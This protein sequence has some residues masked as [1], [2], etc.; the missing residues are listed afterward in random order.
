MC[1]CAWV[2]FCTTRTQIIHKG[3]VQDQIGWLALL[4]MLCN[5][6]QQC[7]SAKPLFP[8]NLGIEPGPYC[9]KSRTKPLCY[10]ALK[11]AVLYVACAVVYTIERSALEMETESMGSNPSHGKVFFLSPLCGLLSHNACCHMLQHVRL[12]TWEGKREE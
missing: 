5:F 10:L 7:Q 1:V 2:C 3:E 6:S 9:L 4:F 12:V 8:H 11:R